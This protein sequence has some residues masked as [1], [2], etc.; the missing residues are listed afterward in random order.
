MSREGVWQKVGATSLRPA[1]QEAADILA[2]IKQGAEVLGRFHTAR[3]PKQLKLYWAMCQIL[4]DHCMFPTKDA[5][6]YAIKVATGHCIL[7][8]FPDDWNSGDFHYAAKSIAFA[9]MEQDAFNEF[10]NAAIE[11]IIERWLP[12]TGAEE[13]KREIYAIVDGPSAIGERAA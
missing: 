7:V 3:N 12:G 13:L 1:S 4:V 10:L 6:D 8:T 11:V 9:S 2:S 5:A